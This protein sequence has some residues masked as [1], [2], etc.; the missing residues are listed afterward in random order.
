[1]RKCRSSRAVL[2][3]TLAALSAFARA[4]NE[5]INGPEHIVIDEPYAY[6]IKCGDGEACREGKYTWKLK[7]AAG[8]GFGVKLNDGKTE[9]VVTSA[10]LGANT[11]GTS[12]VHSVNVTVTRNPNGPDSGEFTLTATAEDGAA[13]EPRVIKWYRAAPNGLKAPALVD[14]KFTVGESYE[15]K[16]VDGQ[17]NSNVPNQPIALTA[18]DGVSIAK[19][20]TALKVGDTVTLGETLKLTLQTSGSHSFSFHQVVRDANN[21]PTDDTDFLIVTYAKLSEI[22]FDPSTLAL[23]KG[24]KSA[25]KALISAEGGELQGEWKWEMSGKLKVQDD[26]DKTNTI[27]FEATGPG[28]ATLD[29]TFTPTQKV[30]DE[31]QKGTPVMGHYEFTVGEAISRISLDL[32]TNTL[33]VGSKTVARVRVFDEKGIQTTLPKKIQLDTSDSLRAKT[34]DET[35]D[36]SDI[37]V[38]ATKESAEVQTLTVTVKLDDD[39][40]HPIK[41]VFEFKVATIADFLPISVKLFQ[42]DDETVRNTFGAEMLRDFFV[43]Q[44]DVLANTK[45]FEQKLGKKIDS[46]I[47]YGSAFDTGVTLQKY[48]FDPEDKSPAGKKK[49]KKWVDVTLDD[50]VGDFTPAHENE[51]NAIP[52]EFKEQGVGRIGDDAIMTRS[53]AGLAVLEGSSLRF[54]INRD[55]KVIILNG[56]DA[57]KEDQVVRWCVARGDDFYLGEAEMNE[58]GTLIGRKAG[59]VKVEAKNQKGTTL[60]WIPVRILPSTGLKVTKAQSTNLAVGIPYF[61]DLGDPTG[62]SFALSTQGVIFDKET[63]LVRGIRAGLV[64]ITATKDTTKYTYI[65]NFMD[66]GSQVELPPSVFDTPDGL[67][68]VKTR[69]RYAP[70]KQEML[71]LSHDQR[72]FSAP[73]KIAERVLDTFGQV[74]GFLVGRGSIDLTSKRGVWPSGVLTLGKPI[75]GLFYPDRSN[76]H[77]DALITQ[78]MKE[79]EEVPANGRL[80]KYIFFPRT[81]ITNMLPNKKVRIASVDT[82]VFRISVGIV[83]KLDAVGENGGQSKQAT[84]SGSGT[85]GGGK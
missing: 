61:L 52:F 54:R 21:R 2:L 64:T 75:L 15:F 12:A 30:G 37:E 65:L 31:T 19:G 41:G 79:I 28:P 33:T 35:V 43:M 48:D 6:A 46:L 59:L 69:F 9:A 36:D 16:L 66:V 80:T 4:D 11:L 82:N 39:P 32:A 10:T 85:G 62:Y 83:S 55:R 49:K 58:A 8:A 20:S 7:V 57:T 13:L 51:S 22:K 26:S 81:D 24:M 60:A 14:T 63:L 76:S 53:G 73:A 77:R 50:V 56:D 67:K 3:A 17:S 72:E 34:I 27:A 40:D 74:L 45:D 71:L 70:V 18:L 78:G 23:R 1:M 29:V 5:A 25:V 38:S 68:R 84:G 47:V 42:V 44:V